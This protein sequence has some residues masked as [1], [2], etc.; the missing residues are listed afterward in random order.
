MNT[1]KFEAY[2]DK[3]LLK[4]DS[5]LYAQIQPKAWI[6]GPGL[7]SNA[8]DPQSTELEKVE[9]EILNFL[10]GDQA[11]RLVTENW[12]THHWL[13]FL[14]GLKHKLDK[15]QVAEL[16][17]VFDLT[18]SGNNEILCDWFQH[19]IA[20]NY[21]PAYPNIATFLK[22]VGRR[23]FLSPLY[24]ALAKTEEGKNWAKEV[25]VEAKPGYHAVSSNSIDEILKD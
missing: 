13:Y 20:V 9:V 7:P 17:H 11:E 4:G 2:L 16:D 21:E 6:Y 22:S 12:T 25:Y 5:A 14:R 1:A 23:K 3:H 10:N 24:E 18:N 8:P 15:N 19:C